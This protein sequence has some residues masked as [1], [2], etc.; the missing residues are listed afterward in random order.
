MPEGD[1]LHRAA[2]ALQSLVGEQVSVRAVHPRARAAGV[3]ERVDGL[4][5]D[6]VSAH[7]KNL[8]LAFD[9]GLVLRS[10]L[11]MTG[12]WRVLPAD[13][14]VRGAPW[15][16]LRG[17][18]CQAVLRGGSRLDLTTRTAARLGPDILAAAFDVRR[19]AARFRK[20]DPRSEIGDVLLDQTIV[21][22]IGN[23][24]RSEALW[25]ACVSPRR[26]VGELADDELVAI[27]EEA[28]RLM[29]LSVRGR[30]PTRQAYR[31]TGRPCTRCRHA[32]ESRRQGEHGRTVY[33]CP[34]CQAGRGD[35]G[36][37]A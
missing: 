10:H 37:G 4:T 22:G 12:S 7:G 33:W 27:L 17:A 18:R 8:L 26:R 5:L 16:V 36:A 13:A 35:G 34:G 24:W 9:G 21:S 25:A 14:D 29:S 20:V 23:I 3:A 32:I 31:R 2:A 1:T 19:A 30:A 28:N 11:G 6:A 15:L